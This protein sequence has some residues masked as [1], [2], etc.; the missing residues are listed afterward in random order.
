[1]T[2]LGGNAEFLAKDECS[3]HDRQPIF[4]LSFIEG[5]Y[6]IT[7]IAYL[8][9]IS[10]CGFTLGKH[11]MRPTQPQQEKHRQAQA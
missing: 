11:R 1:M 2:M 10:L 3:L 5:A 4:S 9:N 6:G 8:K 7:E